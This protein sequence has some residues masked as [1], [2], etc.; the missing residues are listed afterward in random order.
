V[1]DSSDRLA[2][3]ALL[4]YLKNARGFDF[5]SYKRPSLARRVRRRMQEVRAEDLEEYQDYLEVH[6]DEFE[7]LF[8]TILINVTGFFRDPEAWKVLD[9]QIIPAIVESKPRHEPVRAWSAGCASGEEAY[10]LSM[11][12]AETLG[13][14]EARQRVKIYA[15]DVDTGALD[16]A[17][18]ATY[19]TEAMQAV[20]EAMRERYFERAG[21]SYAFRGDLR[22]T[23]IFGRHDLLHDAP[24]SRLD[25]LICRNTLIY[26]NRDAQKRI[27]ARFHFALNDTGYLF[28]GKAEMLLGHSSLFEPLHLKHR[29]FAKIPSQ[30]PRDRMMVLAQAGDTE[31]VGQLGSYVRMREAAFD[32]SPVAQVVVDRDGSLALINKQ[33]Y[34]LFD[35]SM[36]D[37]GRPFQDL[38]LS[39]QPVELRSLMERARGE[40]RSVGIRDIE[41]PLR[42]GETCF[43]DVEV[44]RLEQNGGRYL[45]ISIS[46][47]DVTERKRLRSAA[48]HAREE[49]ETTHEEL[50][51]TN[52]ELET[53]NEELQS[54]VEELQTTN[55]ELQS[56][57]EES[58]TVNEELQSTNEEL[59]TMNNELHERTRELNQA[60]AFLQ[61]ILASVDIGIVVL[62]EDFRIQLWNNRAEDLWGLRPDEVTGRS[63]LHLNI[64][65]PV[66]E[67]R[68][69]VNRFLLNDGEC[70]EIVL[71]ARNRRGQSIQCRI[72]CTRQFDI[73][74]RTTGVVLLMEEEPK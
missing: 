35:L 52:E 22:R 19:N 74:G 31:A 29:V 47:R 2:L 41:C 69:P 65:L 68:D 33:A 30:Q 25:L 40:R 36:Q 27:F 73:D 44:S 15:T 24:I 10:T 58:E 3:E 70:E 8:D 39:Y 46:F 9:E 6:P 34:A 21:G 60:N 14:D 42:N 64:G 53:S 56:M 45:G 57:N 12:L 71:E 59:Q 67:L 11:L 26:F 13:V 61:S 23:V 54:A 7:L 50:Q 43:L 63:L 72:S 18:Q 16:L 55:E 20:P 17:R 66:G 62:D 32:T 49:A 4:D 37:I 1:S 28:L 38:R 51:A 48:Q 5:T